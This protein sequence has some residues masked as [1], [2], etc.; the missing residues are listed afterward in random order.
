MP[1]LSTVVYFTIIL[2]Y[3][4]VSYNCNVYSYTLIIVSVSIILLN[5]TCLVHLTSWLLK[6]AIAPPSGHQVELQTHD[7]WDSQRV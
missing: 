3:F 4:I 7:P 5:M 2:K 6:S 1:E